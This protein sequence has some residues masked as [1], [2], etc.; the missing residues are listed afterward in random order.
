MLKKT[1]HDGKNWFS[2]LD[3]GKEM[4]FTEGYFSIHDK[5][6][7]IMKNPEGDKFISDMIDK[8]SSEA[9]INVSK[10]ML[11]MAKNFTIEKIFEMAG[12]RIPDNAKVWVSE[13]LAN[14]K[15]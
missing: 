4:V 11:S 15:K 2:Y 7:D 12:D 8:I 3:G 14:I 13:Q 9:G 10:G 1:K 5:L 6:G